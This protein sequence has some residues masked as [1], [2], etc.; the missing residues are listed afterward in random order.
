[1]V[2]HT[3]APVTL[4]AAVTGSL[5]ARRVQNHV[6]QYRMLPDSELGRVWS[7]VAAAAPVW[8]SVLMLCS[9]YTLYVGPFWDSSIQES[10]G[11]NDIEW[12]NFLTI[13]NVSLMLVL[14]PGRLLDDYSPA[15]VS[16]MGACLAA[17]GYGS[18]WYADALIL[19]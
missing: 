1:M 15:V 12:R 16:L 14:L 19:P 5:V 3:L 18:L 17:L 6:E 9:S 4:S 11:A 2:W 10:C 13:T 8:S 7:Q